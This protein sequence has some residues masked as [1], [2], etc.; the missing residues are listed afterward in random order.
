MVARDSPIAAGTPRGSPPIERDVR[1]LD[2]DVRPGADRDPEVRLGERRRVVDPVADHRDRSAAG[3][4]AL[5]DGRPCRPDTLGDDAMGRDPDLR[6]RRPRRGPRVAGH[7]PD[8][9]AS[10]RELAHGGRRLGLDRVDDG[11]EARRPAID[12]HVRDRSGPPGRRPRAPRRA[13]R[14]RCRARRAGA[15]CRRCT[16]RDPRAVSTDARTPPPTTAANPTTRPNPSSSR[17]ARRDDR[18][19][20][21]VFARALERTRRGRGP[22][23]AANPGATTTSATVGRPS[24]SVPGLVEHDGVDSM[25]DLERLAAADQD[26]GLGAAAGP[27]HD[28]CRGGQA[29]RARAGDDDDADERREGQGEARLRAEDQPH[30]ERADGDDQDDRHEHLGDPVRQPLDRRLAALGATDEVDDPGE[31]RVAPDPRRAHHERAGRV[32]GRPDDLDAGG[33]PRPGSARR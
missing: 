13:A 5:D 16:S 18:G 1:R 17:F 6:G 9:D 3:L 22:R 11:D 21:R 2:R 20:E 28:R 32:E 23:A 15:D 19:P 10:G 8:L 27:D 14:R 25:G 30:D 24:V 7:Q 33:R 12:G 26:A 29:H 4:E 31:R